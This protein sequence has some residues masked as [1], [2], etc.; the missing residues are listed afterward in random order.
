[1]DNGYSVW[2]HDPSD[3]WLARNAGNPDRLLIHGVSLDQ[4]CSL[5][6]TLFEM[7]D[8]GENPHHYFVAHESGAI[9]EREITDRPV[10]PTRR[11]LGMRDA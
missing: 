3:D 1:M 10:R 6:D 5:R 8:T 9:V 7:H 2:G 11:K 4:A